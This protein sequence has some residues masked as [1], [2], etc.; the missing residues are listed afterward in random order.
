MLKDRSNKCTKAKPQEQSNLYALFRVRGD[1]NIQV[2]KGH[3]TRHACM[4]EAYEQGYVHFVSTDIL[5]DVSGHVI[6]NDYFVGEVPK[7]G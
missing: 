2:S 1:G 4:I 3:S 6:C 7:D 5:N